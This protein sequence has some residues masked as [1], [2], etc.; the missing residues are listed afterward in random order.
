VRIASGIFGQDRRHR[1]RR[2]AG[3]VLGGV[4]LALAAQP[5]AAEVTLD[6]A[7]GVQGAAAEITFK[8]SEDRA[9]A[10]WTKQIDIVMPDGSPVAEVYPLSNDEWGPRIAYRELATALP[11]VH[12][13]QSNSVVTS[14]SWLRFGQ[15][16]A[17]VTTATT[18][19][20][21]ISLGPLPA[22]DNLRFLVVQTYSDGV[23]KRW[24]NPVMTLTAPD[25]QPG[26][27]A[28]VPGQA[29]HGHS[30]ALPGGPE[31]AAERDGGGN[32]GI[33]VGVLVALVIGVAIGVAVVASSRMRPAAADDDEDPPAGDDT[34]GDVEDG[35][36][37]AEAVDHRA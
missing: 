27:P 14:I 26:T 12:G 3:T 20:L 8:V 31:A 29:G 32:V 1:L 28:T 24:P 17:G 13:T 16:A 9:P 21:R 35:K 5:A 36:P 33:V 4:L 15:P 19:D 11:G 30:G 22:T 6:P 10:A 34:A 18:N 2:A 25:G 7:T 37:A 23:V